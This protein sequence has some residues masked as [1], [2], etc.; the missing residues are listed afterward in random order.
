MLT[1]FLADEWQSTGVAVDVAPEAVAVVV[2]DTR[3]YALAEQR[4]RIC[5]R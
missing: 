5:C 4:L 3:R 2:V 1:L